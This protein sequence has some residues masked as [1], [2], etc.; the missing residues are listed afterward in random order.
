MKYE[1]DIS[2]EQ[3]ERI[4]KYLANQLNSEEQSHFE[5]ELK[6]SPELQQ[7]MEW[8]KNT[9]LGIESAVLREQLDDFH[10]DISTKGPQKLESKKSGIAKWYP[11]AAILI[12]ALGLF[13]FMQPDQNLKIYNTYFEPDPGL[14]TTMSSNND[15]DFYDGMVNYKQGDYKLAISKWE[16]LKNSGVSTDTLLY[17]LGVS[18]LANGNHDNAIYYLKPLSE[19]TQ[20]SFKEDTYYY[21]G[22]AFLKADNVEDAKKYLT[23]SSAE[24]AKEVLSRIE[25]D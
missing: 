1:F 11:V 12:V 5:N 19:A 8:V 23:F 16:E 6:S 20:N 7:K 18:H 17:F 2:E 24:R 15:F 4:E 22:M 21:L 3:L 25:T 13:W 10:S 9:A 14:P